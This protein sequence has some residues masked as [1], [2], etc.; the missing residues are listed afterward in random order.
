MEQIRM[1]ETTKQ[2]NRPSE[3][4]YPGDYY[5]DAGVLLSSLEAQGLWGHMLWRVMWFAPI[6][7]TLCKAN[8]KQMSSQELAKLAGI[9]V[10]ECDRL[11]AE[12][13]ENGVYSTYDDGTIY[14]RRMYGKWRLSRVRAEA[15]RKGGKASGTSKKEAK[16]PSPTPTPTS[17]PT[18]TPKEKEVLL[19]AA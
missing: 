1:G 17:S 11:V 7:G 18:P 3:Q 14:N 19:K 5:A 4:F 8:G 2:D 6:R 9:S 10:E 15:G 13:G 16:T 12:L